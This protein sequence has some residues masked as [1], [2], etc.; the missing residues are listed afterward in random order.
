MF[1]KAPN[2]TVGDIYSLG[3]LFSEKQLLRAVNVLY[4]LHQ[5]GVSLHLMETTFG[6][7]L[8]FPETSATLGMRI[9]L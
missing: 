5:T 4:D 9:A 7:L 6:F 2:K 1:L 3:I 8:P